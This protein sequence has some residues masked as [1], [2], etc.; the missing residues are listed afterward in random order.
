MNSVKIRNAE[1]TDVNDLVELW[2]VLVIEQGTGDIVYVDDLQ[3]Q[4]VIKNSYLKSIK[5]EPRGFFVAEVNNK[6]VGF[7]KASTESI[8]T[9]LR[10]QRKFG[11][12]NGLVVKEEYRRR[13]IGTMLVEHCFKYLK[14]NGIDSALLHV[15]HD[16][17]PAIRLYE[18]LGFEL[19]QIQM[20]KDLE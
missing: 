9:P 19:L 13:D 3:N 18:K 14:G 11:T 15:F 20:V 7:A 8:L 1:E 17:T 5:E 16:N 4:K 2:K 10:T 6:V 12:I